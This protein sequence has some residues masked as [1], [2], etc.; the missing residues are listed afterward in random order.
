MQPLRDELKEVLQQD[1]RLVIDGTL[2]KNKIIELALKLDKDLLKLLLDND[3]LKEHFF[4]DVD[5][6]YVFDKQTFQKFISNKEFLPDSYTA[7]KNKIGLSANGENYFIENN[8]VSLIWPYKDCVLEGGQTKEDSKRDEIFWNETLAPDQIDRL[9]DPKAFT[10]FKKF[11]ENG[12]QTVDKFS[13]DDDYVIK[14]NNLLALHSLKKV[15]AGKVKLIY[16]D[17]PYNTGNDDFGYND[18]FNHSAWLTFMK[19]RLQIARDLL[20]KDGSLW[21]NIDDDESHYLKVLTDEVMGKENFVANVLWQKRTSPDARATLGDAHDHILVFAKQYELFKETLNTLPLTE[22]QKSRYTNPDDDPRGPWVSSDFTAQGYRPNQMYEIETPSGE[23]YTPPPGRCWKNVEEEYIRQHEE[24]RMWY[25]VNND[26][27]PRRKTYLKESDGRVAW[28][29]WPNEEVGH[30]QEAKKESIA[31]FSESDPFSTPK[32]ERLL[33]RIIRLGTNTGDLVLDFFAG[34]GTTGAV[35]HKM[36]RQYIMCEQMDYVE[37][38]TVKRLQKVI[39]GEQGGISEEVEWKGGGSF[40]YGELMAFNARFIDQIEDADSKEAIQEVWEQMQDNAFLSYRIDPNDINE[41]KETFDELSLKEQKQFLIEVLD[42]NQ[43]YVNY[44]EI[45]DE[46]Y[47]ISE[48]EQELNH[49]FYSM[50]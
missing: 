26:A 8:D 45:E 14:G 17:P 2:A 27:M 10:N 48:E 39:E 41:S 12:E 15:Y 1:E 9:L 50:K 22:E 30:N 20:S 37:P 29:W 7:F 6:T 11:D 31:L 46:D 34:S 21:I 4:Q 44:S 40:V 28:S 38:V 13:I 47:G 49:N 43:L 3:R 24:G 35:A 33:Q 36:G 23:T 42:K 25:G 5:G 19:N 18:R 32:P 16:I